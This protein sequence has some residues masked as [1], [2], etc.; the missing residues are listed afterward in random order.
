MKFPNLAALAAT[1]L[2]VAGTPVFAAPSTV[3]GGV[4]KTSAASSLSPARASS[5][6]R[7]GAKMR[8][9]NSL[10]GNNGLGIAMLAIVGAGAVWAAIEMSKDDND[11][12]ASP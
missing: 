3:A 2:I 6:G 1:S 5:V 10:A 11:S 4:Q 8:G 9:A 7:V 12:P